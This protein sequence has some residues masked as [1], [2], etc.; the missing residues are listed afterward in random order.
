MLWMTSASELFHSR[1]YRS[2]LRHNAVSITG[3][4][5]SPAD[6]T[7]SSSSYQHRSTIRRHSQHYSSQNN[8]R[9]S[10]LPASRRIHRRRLDPLEHQSVNPEEGGSHPPSG[11]IVSSD[12]LR[13]IHRHSR[14]VVSGNDRLPGSVLLARERL[15]E[16]LRGVSVSGNRQTSGSSSTTHQNDFSTPNVLE[17]RNSSMAEMV[18]E[19]WQE[20][21]KKNYPLGLN[22][23]ELKCLQLDAFTFSSES[24]RKKDETAS[25]SM[26]CTICLEGFE[27]GD[28]MVCLLC[29]HRFH[30]CLFPWVRV[31]GACPNCR[32][33]ILVNIPEK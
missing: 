5:S 23:D 4:D 7:S 8:L 3:F 15:V 13:S 17:I 30:S 10:C 12:G 2:G 16:R 21:R 14:P 20:T 32:K 25:A 22:E 24:C 1:R 9:D 26:E 28:K 19:S 31:C 33:P 6:V 11:S 18:S 29:T 27:D